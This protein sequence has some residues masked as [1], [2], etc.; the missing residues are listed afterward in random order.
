MRGGEPPVAEKYVGA[1][2]AEVGVDEVA[3]VESEAGV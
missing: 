2:E 1:G 3:M